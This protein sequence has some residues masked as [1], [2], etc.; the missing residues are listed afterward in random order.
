M[1]CAASCGRISNLVT[2]TESNSNDGSTSGNNPVT[3]SA[4]PRDDV[5]RASKKFTEQNSFQATMDG[6]GSKDMHIELG[7]IAPDRYHIKN[8]PAMESIIIGKDTYLKIGGAWKKFS[9]NLS[10][11]I[12]KMRDAFTEEGMKSLGEVEYVG[13]DAVNGKSALLYRYQGSAI[14]DGASY[15]SKLWVGKDS[16][17][18]LK[19]EVEYPAGGALKQMTTT[20]DYDAKV[21][22]ESP[23][24]N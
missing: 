16:G 13:E 14:K 9:A 6:K 10:E 15:T 22:I 17:L 24:V 7:Y 20:Y 5:I 1:F 19:I 4:N 21:A 18:P 8:A 11:S 23:T 3:A 2:K 12:P